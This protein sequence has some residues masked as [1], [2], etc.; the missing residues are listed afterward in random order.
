MFIKHR[1]YLTLL[2]L[3]L[4]PLLLV[5]AL[6][7]Q[8]SERALKESIEHNFQKLVHEKADSIGRH[9]DERI[10]ET[11]M[12]ATHPTII[13]A[14][15]EANSHYR[16]QDKHRVM[17]EIDR[18]DKAWIDSKGATDKADQLMT[19]DT[20][21]LLTTIQ[22]RKPESYGEIF[23]TDRLGASVAS[24]KRLSD[25]YQADEYWWQAGSQYMQ[26]GAFL[27]DRG[28]DASVGA[29][30]I[31]VVVPVVDSG[32]MIGV[33]KIN[34]RVRSIIN[35]ISDQE[36]IDPGHELLLVRSDGSIITSSDES[37]PKMLN[38]NE[39]AIIKSKE[40]GH[41]EGMRH[42]KALLSAY[43]PM[44]HTFSTRLTTGAIKGVT[45]E[46]T[47]I[48]RWYVIY[49]VD[50]EIAFAALNDLAVIAIILAIMALTLSGL[51]GFLLSRAITRPLSILKSG[52]T[53]IGGGDL[54]H[55]ITLA[56]RDEFSSLAH[57]FNKMALRLQ[58]ANSSRDENALK[59]LSITDAAYDAI[60]VAGNDGNIV[61]WNKAAEKLFGFQEA[62]TIGHPLTE[63]IIPEKQRE[64]HR[65]GFE[66]F[67][68]T[69][70]GAVLGTTIELMALHK[71]GHEFLVEL[72]LSPLKLK[73]KWHAVG[74][75]RD[76]TERKQAEAAILD[77]KHKL[78]ELMESV[79][80]G[81]T[82]STLEGQITEAN[83]VAV[84]MF[85]YDSKVS[86][87]AA[88]IA[89][90]YGNPQDRE[91]FIKLLKERP[92]KDFEVHFKHKDGHLFWCSVSS[93]I[94]STQTETV[95][96]ISAF[97]D[98]TERRQME[99]ELYKLAQVVEQSPVSIVIT[100][101]DAEIEYVNDAF[102]DASGYNLK[103]LVGQNPRILQSGKTPPESYTDLWNK[104][105][106]GDSWKGE[107]YN[108]KKD[109]TEIIEFA[110][111]F[112]I[113]HPD[114]S[115]SQYTA[116]KEDIT[117]KK[118]FSQE[119]DEHRNHLEDM[120][121][122]RTS[123]LSQ[124]QQQAESANQAKSAFL[125][126]M[127]HEIRTPMNAIIGLT[128]LLKNAGPTPEQLERL[129]K[130]DTASKH[131]LSIINDI[132]D[133]SKIES[134]K[135]ILEQ[136][137]FH[138]NAI[139]DNVQSLLREQADAKELTFEVDL[140]NVQH[141]LRG[142]P[143]RL[144]QALLNYV[145]NAVK[146]SEKGI[147]YLRAKKIKENN[148]EIL[149]QFEVQDTGV[150]IKPDR[151]SNLFEA[152]EQADSSTTRKYG[153]TGLG[154][155]ITSRLAHLMG[156]GV[157][158]E[159]EPGQ[160]STFWFTVWLKRGHGVIPNIPVPEAVD[161]PMELRNHYAGSRI[162]LV[163]DNAINKEVA[164]ELLS[165]VGMAV[166][167]AENGCEAVE[168][169]RAGSYDLVLMDIQMPVMDG[170]EATNLIRT[171]IN[172]EELP[173]LAMSANVFEESRQAS[174]VVGMNDFVAKPVDPENLYSTIIKWLPERE[175]SAEVTPAPE[176]PVQ[177]SAKVA[178]LQE[179]LTTIEGIDVETGLHNICCDVAGYLRLL[180]LFDS[181]HTEDMLKLAGHLTDGEDE[182][183][184]RIPHTIKGSAGTLGLPHLQEAAK[185]LEQYLYDHG[186]N[187]D[188]DELKRLMEVVS[189]KQKS[190]H[191][192][193]A[194]IESK[195]EPVSIVEANPLEAQAVLERLA[196][197]LTI[198][199]A[200]VNELFLESED[201]L[202]QSFGT[203][204]EQLGQQINSFN[205]P[206]ALAILE[207]IATSS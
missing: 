30:V 158:A 43:Y 37:H 47:Q 207:S 78:K 38:E 104:L 69:G 168:K 123:Q 141:W 73:G 147:I 26:K 127:S 71:D 120:V 154:L 50:Q 53:I 163:E 116:V 156:G 83:N 171:T 130:I 10:N 167:T 149:V 57:S 56:A 35:I 201:L 85:G 195:K 74:I 33:L 199:D 99:G 42:G 27:D 182:D 81:I 82:V 112:P 205:Y 107:L 135:L 6:T 87:M 66:K 75:L 151:L 175:I 9:L 138:L 133:I 21:H 12:L 140:D 65:K 15:Q 70:V 117:E 88:S 101:L 89:D 84:E 173:I 148:D 186:N 150:G 176:R 122:T 51:S 3:S 169:V 41:W 72:S 132:L 44:K 1:I 191:E 67:S 14:L 189:T 187:V 139:F 60:I 103:E 20:S 94:H 86:F 134:G 180:R 29:I 110:M 90:R 76:I 143:T 28:F 145:S 106:H 79:P 91:R 16:G 202:K 118:R 36:G 184:R 22:A 183:A 80:I 32:E 157:G 129:N 58:E 64:K 92:V 177:Q 152:F 121:V 160:G 59:L 102:V 52:I 159:S 144:R 200:S 109:G 193:L 2:L 124:A 77:S 39:I 100:N 54:K 7:E 190:L 5:T 206:E 126:N 142:D 63:L 166:D 198:N 146:F 13:A 114:G 185:R 55:R 196:E 23:L 178:A 62:D 174:L 161:I 164:V 105:T 172:K 115:I 192:S 204:A 155:V 46:T 108:R 131:L 125:A 96:Y 136:T 95:Q 93:V 49:E 97:M 194:Y 128:H 68:C 45:G 113:C 25:Y 4:L 119:L 11:R 197:L 34:F 188:D 98:I 111:I 165:S 24:T 18:L 170:L 8:M 17:D 40:I 31:G 48:K 203:A 179:Q 153:G 137:D 181:T 162:L 61:F 19:N